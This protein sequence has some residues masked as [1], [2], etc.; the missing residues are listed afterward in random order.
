MLLLDPQPK[1]K[2]G[3]NAFHAKSPLRP[4]AVMRSEQ[5]DS[6]GLAGVETIHP[7]TPISHQ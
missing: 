3:R 6:S 4:D 5:S 1:T 2:T 7:P